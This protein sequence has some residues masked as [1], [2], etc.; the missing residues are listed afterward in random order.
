MNPA[1]SSQD[2]SG[3]TDPHLVQQPDKTVQVLIPA[4]SFNNI[5]FFILFWKD[6]LHDD[7][8]KMIFL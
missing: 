2:K 5:S 8:I 3:P 1:Q 7:N 6:Q 4:L